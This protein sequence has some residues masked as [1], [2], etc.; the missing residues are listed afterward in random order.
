MRKIADDGTTVVIVEQNVG[1]LP[2]AD[3][4]LVME[5]GTL[6]Y[7]GDAHE[8]ERTG[9]LQKAYLGGAA[10]PVPRSAVWSPPAGTGQR[11]RLLMSSGRRA[12]CACSSAETIFAASARWL[13]AT[14]RAAPTTTRARPNMPPLIR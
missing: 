6:T 3:R 7:D 8:L 10:G 11:E 14:T 1:I 2:Y 9:D 12:A 5:K 13:W 4:A